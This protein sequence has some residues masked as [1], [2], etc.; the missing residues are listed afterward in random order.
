M[1]VMKGLEPNKRYYYR[2]GDRK[3]LTFSKVKYF[4]SP[5][6]RSQ[7]LETMNIAVFG[8]MGTFAPFG[9]FVIDKIAKDNLLTPFNLV[10]LT[11]DIA[12]AGVNNYERGES[13][14]IWDLFGELTEKFA[15]YTAFMPGVGNH[16]SYYNFTAYFNR[17]ILPRSFPEQTNFYFSFDYGQVHFVHFSSEHPYGLGS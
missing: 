13:A 15:A 3:T 6:L 12:Y 5:P 2:V 9:N 17:Y 8:D 10:F 16:E 4:T 7:S 1:A 11:G 14:P